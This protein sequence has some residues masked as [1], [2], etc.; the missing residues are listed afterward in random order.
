MEV[1]RERLPPDLAQAL[2]PFQ[3]CGESEKMSSVNAIVEYPMCPANT[4]IRSY[5]V[6]PLNFIQ[7]CTCKKMGAWGM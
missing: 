4:S 3:A 5:M 7:L 1:A 2:L 6:A